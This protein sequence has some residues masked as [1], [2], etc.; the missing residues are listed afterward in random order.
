MFKSHG[1]NAQASSSQE[2][3]TGTQYVY[4]PP[5]I[6][7]DTP[8][9]FSFSNTTHRSSGWSGLKS[10]VTGLQSG[11]MLFRETVTL[12]ISQMQSEMK[13][14]S[15]VA[16]R[17]GE[18]II[19]LREENKL[20]RGI[21]T[22][23]AMS[24]KSA[25]LLPPG[26]LWSQNEIAEEGQDVDGFIGV[27][28]NRVHTKRYF[29]S[30]IAEN[31]EKEKIIHFLNDKGIMPTLISLFPS[32]WKGTQSA[33]INVQAKDG[34]IIMKD[35][36]WPQHMRCRQWKSKRTLYGQRQMNTKKSN[37]TQQGQRYSTYV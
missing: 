8:S 27:K 20:L 17:Q 26:K 30:G 1:K 28:K 2:V 6:T 19:A 5:E 13:R 3:D 32:K 7:A 31:V 33:K 37:Y 29:I 21:C 16:E 15:E 35:D 25:V 23:H 14:L 22:A 34:E 36:F 24:E 4:S 11:Y 10:Q 18:E 9:S 12:D